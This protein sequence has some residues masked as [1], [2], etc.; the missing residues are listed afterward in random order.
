MSRIMAKEN[1][2]HKV[3]HLGVVCCHD[4]QKIPVT[5][6][7]EL[8]LNG[9]GTRRGRFHLMAT[10]LLAVSDRTGAW[11]GIDTALAT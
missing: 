6:G 9:P 11:G 2:E 5:Y 7:M 3:E 1:A 10:R 8:F 4:L